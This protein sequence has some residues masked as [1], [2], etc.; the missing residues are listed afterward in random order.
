MKRSKVVAVLIMLAMLMAPVQVLPAAATPTV[1]L[2]IYYP[3]SIAADGHAYPFLIQAYADAEQTEPAKVNAT[4]AVTSSSGSLDPSTSTVTM[5]NGQ[6]ILY[7]TANKAGSGLLKEH[8][9]EVTASILGAVPAIVNVT[10]IPPYVPYT[11][12]VAVPRYAAAGQFP[13]VI[14]AE[15]SGVPVATNL[16]MYATTNATGSKVVS[17]H[18]DVGQL[19]ALQAGG[20]FTEVSVSGNGFSVGKNITH[21]VPVTASTE[22]NG[23]T[24]HIASVSTVTLGIWPVILYAT[25]PVVTKNSTSTWLVPIGKLDATY[26]TLTSSVP[27]IASV[28]NI[29]SWSNNYFIGYLN[30]THTGVFNLTVQG[31]GFM[32]S[33]IMLKSVAM[34]NPFRIASFGPIFTSGKTQLILEMLSNDLPGLPQHISLAPIVDITDNSTANLKPVNFFDGFAFISVDGVGDVDVYI[35]APRVHTAH[36]IIGTA[37]GLFK[38]PPPPPPPSYNLTLNSNVNMNFSIK[39][40]NSAKPFRETVSANKTVVIT[41]A[42]A[43]TVPQNFLKGTTLYSF[44]SWQDNSTSLTRIANKTETLFAKYSITNVGIYVGSNINFTLN[45]VKDG[46]SITVPLNKTFVSLSPINI[47]LPFTIPGNTPG[48]QF[49][50]SGWSDHYN[51][52][53]RSLEPGGNYSVTYQLQYVVNATSQYGQVDGAGYHNANSI[54]R[55]SMSQTNYQVWFF[56]YARLTGY[57]INGQ[58]V[59]GQSA[60]FVLTGPSTVKAEF[61]VDYTMLIVVV[62]IAAVAILGGLFLLRRFRRRSA[63]LKEE[64]EEEFGQI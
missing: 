36:I 3:P 56:V 14:S 59:K 33:T 52:L 6:A 29:S 51:S 50:F 9:V 61:T 25:A 20:N 55:I 11:T 13:A 24:L 44:I 12:N 31:A 17:F 46:K 47:T 26:Y 7:F 4:V 41:Q 1:H 39:G 42:V 43:V 15:S 63:S 37:P 32:S 22:V 5:I 57:I 40:L 34:N 2:K 49:I 45:G 53:K 35:H 27:S 19:E 10:V 54:V 16:T 23:A 62:A 58:E 8:N 21:V 30:V 28:I 60:S 48:S 38:Q 18:Q 64:N